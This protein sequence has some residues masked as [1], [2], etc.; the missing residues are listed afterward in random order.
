MRGSPTV[1]VTADDWPAFFDLATGS[2]PFA[3]VCVFGFAA[4]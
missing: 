2:R 3:E 4:G 1:A